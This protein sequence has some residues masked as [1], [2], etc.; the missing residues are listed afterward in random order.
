MNNE[1]CFSAFL[2]LDLL[3][4]NPDKMLNLECNIVQHVSCLLLEPFKFIKYI[5]CRH[6]FWV[7]VFVNAVVHRIKGVLTDHDNL[8]T[9]ENHIRCKFW[10]KYPLICYNYSET[11]VMSMGCFNWHIE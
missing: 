6:I 9:T 1:H 7:L 2:F 11:T 8:K 5:I 3:L 4:A 10:V